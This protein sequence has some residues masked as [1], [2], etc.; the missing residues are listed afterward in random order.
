MSPIAGQ[1]EVR[2]SFGASNRAF[3]TWRGSKNV[4]W[5]WG[6]RFRP[7]GDKRPNP[8]VCLSQTHPSRT[9]SE[10]ARCERLHGVLEGL[11]H[12]HLL[13]DGE[14]GQGVI[15]ERHIQ[16][17]ESSGKGWGAL[18]E[19]KGHI[20][21]PDGTESEFSANMLNSLNVG[22]LYEG[23]IVPVRYDASDHSK[24]VIDVDALEAQHTADR[25]SAVEVMKEHAAARV[26]QADA[27][28]T[29][30]AGQQGTAATTA[31]DTVDELARLAA[32]KQSGAL[33]QAEF[34]AEKQK[35]LDR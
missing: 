1:K 32:L 5:S 35:L 30:M 7:S 27:Q 4:C 31:G 15:T 13:K 24:V 9:C 18:F 22:D 25:D 33:T 10:P 12:H 19:I 14:Q 26:E 23:T 29:G 6:R 34:D 17:Q 8:G 11:L 28:L 20:K 16:G 3:A 21:F 2:R